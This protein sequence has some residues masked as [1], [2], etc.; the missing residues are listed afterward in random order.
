MR[1][2]K[3]DPSPKEPPADAPKQPAPK[4]PCRYENG[5]VYEPPAEPPLP[6]VPDQGFDGPA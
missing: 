6:F 4:E 2:L 1:T 5:E 3:A